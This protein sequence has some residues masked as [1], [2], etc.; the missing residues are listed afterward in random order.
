MNILRLFFDKK[1]PSF[2]KKDFFLLLSG[3]VLFLIATLSTISLPS[4]WFDEAFGAYL[5]RF[6]FFEI[7]KYTAADVHPPLYYWLLK[8]WSL[9]FGNSELALR[10]MSVMFGALSIILGYLLVKKLFNQKA[11]MLGVM[12][13]SITPMFVRYSQ[14]ARMYT[15]V[16]AIA[17]AATLVMVYALET[18]KSKLWIYYGILVGL[19]MLTHYFAA[20]IWITHWLW[21]LIVVH[22]QKP[23]K[24]LK[25]YFSKDWI[26]AHIVAIILFLP[27]LPFF[28]S[29][30]FTV[31][32]F[33]F[34][35]P[36]VTPDTIVNF[37]T[38]NFFYQDANNLVGW[39]ALAFILIMIIL[40]GLTIVIYK[41]LEIKQRLSYS[42]II[43]LALA[44]IAILV[45]L[46]MPPLR[47]S[48][49]DRYL[50]TSSLMT[51][52]LLAVSLSIYGGMK[53]KN[54]S[55]QLFMGLL[56]IAVMLSGVVNVWIQGNY[57][58]NS[59]ASNNT[60]QI[61]DLV[62]ARSANEPIVAA[63]PWLYYEVAFYDSVQNP[64]SFIE[65]NEYL[66]G[67]LVMLEENDD[68]KIKNLDKFMDENPVFWY[69]GY[70]SE[71]RLDSPSSRLELIQEL[72]FNDTFNQKPAYIAK[73]YKLKE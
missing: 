72:Y 23:K 71:G 58:K 43:L 22:S 2:A 16:V 4:I 50:I 13:M 25:T 57:N 56:I 28:I 73:Q 5:I 6:D 55:K 21:R 14:E 15:L 12:L 19:G 70:S 66:Y 3:S 67:S 68:H 41:G 52:I 40:I 42:L 63:T 54:V 34:W 9:L 11:A 32:A 20:L 18:K 59:H 1:Q 51:S 10:S 65:P 33:G 17:L 64:V 61:V 27:W 31:Q 24:F 26:V 53:K 38:N 49:I 47:S 48:F 8:M 62:K 46:S 36:P 30:L 69:V 39:P 7:A 45:L 29:Q 60:R 44:P 35:I 37:F